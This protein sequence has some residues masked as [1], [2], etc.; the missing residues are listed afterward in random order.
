MTT[1]EIIT[2]TTIVFI[3]QVIFIGS[4]TWN[5]KSIAGN[6]V[7]M[8]VLSGCV[9]NISWMITTGLSTISMYSCIQNFDWQYIPI[10]AASVIGGA[11]GGF[12]GMKSK[13]KRR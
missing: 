7:F 6:N 10:I 8:V 2:H 3:T 12:V 5:V 9:V 1:A 11:V 4:R 13:P